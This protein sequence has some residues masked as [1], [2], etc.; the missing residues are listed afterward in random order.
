MV[1]VSAWQL[2]PLTGE[3]AVLWAHP[4]GKRGIHGGRGKTLDDGRLG[5]GAQR[6]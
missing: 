6:D 4:D 2:A 1:P 3:L 5:G